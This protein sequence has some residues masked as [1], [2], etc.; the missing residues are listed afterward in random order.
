[1]DNDVLPIWKKNNYSCPLEIVIRLRLLYL[2][3]SSFLRDPS[4][5]FFY[6]IIYLLIIDIFIILRISRK[7][8][9]DIFNYYTL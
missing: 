8:Y 6:N 3:L 7:H 1:V 9:L 2:Y 5:F 4:F